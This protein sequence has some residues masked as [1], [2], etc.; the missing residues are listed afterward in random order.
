MLDW[1]HICRT[2]WP[3]NSSG[4][5]QI[6]YK[7]ILCNFGQINL[8]RYPEDSALSREYDTRHNGATTSFQDVLVDNYSLWCPGICATTKHYNQP[9]LTEVVIYWTPPCVAS[10]LM[11]KNRCYVPSVVVFYRWVLL[12]EDKT[13]LICVSYFSHWMWMW[14]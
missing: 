13:Y 10:L 2:C 1:A 12:M 11:Y 8:I 9:E 6:F 4:V 3:Y 14:S 5:A 7:P